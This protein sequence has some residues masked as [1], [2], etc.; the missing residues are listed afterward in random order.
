MQVLRLAALVMGASLISTG[1]NAQS[2]PESYKD[3]Q[4][5]AV[6]T[7]MV[8]ALGGAGARSRI[9]DSLT[10]GTITIFD[11]AG[12]QATSVIIKTRG[13][14][15]IRYERTKGTATTF[16]VVDKGL[17]WYT[18]RQQVF[19]IPYSQS[20]REI[21]IHL[22]LLSPISDPTKSDSRIQYSGISLLENS[23][24][25]KIAFID[26]SLENPVTRGK[27]EKDQVELL[28]DANTFLPLDLRLVFQQDSVNRGTDIEEYRL[29]EYRSIESVLVP[30]SI[31]QLINGIRAA[32]I[33]ISDVKFNTG[34]PE[35]Q[36]EA[37]I[38]E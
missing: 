1:S 38:P 27:K 6:L 32:Q 37:P 24:V 10:T 29:S 8:S 31:T 21:I 16:Y 36:F 19:R 17:G 26:E 22:P 7:R 30:C 15:E 34:I 28:V 12:Q 14:D 3:P 25:Y 33:D 20:H 4:A 13:V 35:S 5:L 2:Q 18:R 9:T 11:P 23:T